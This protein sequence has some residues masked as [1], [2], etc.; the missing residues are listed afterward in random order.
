MNREV[1]GKLKERKVGS[2]LSELTTEMKR[3]EKKKKCHF[4]PK[5]IAI[6]LA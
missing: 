5:H 1:G 6:P 3:K 4:F 2:K